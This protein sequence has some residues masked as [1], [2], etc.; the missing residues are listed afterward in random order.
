MTDVE[1]AEIRDFLRTEVPFNDL[2]TTAVDALPGKL[3]VQ[4]FRRASTILRAGVDNDSLFIVRSGAVELTDATGEFM[5]RVDVGRSFGSHSLLSGQP[6]G[7]T[8]T[9]LEDTLALVMP[10][11]VFH[12]LTAAHPAFAEFFDLQRASRMRG[13]VATLHMSAMGGA[14]LKTRVSSILSRPAVTAPPM[15][16][17]REAATIMTVSKVSS[18]L[19]VEDNDVVGIVTDRDLRSRALAIGMDPGHPVKSIMTK[20]PVTASAESLAFEVLMEMLAR[21]IH[22]LP[23]VRDGE[24]AGVITTTD[25]MRLEQANPVFLV[26]DI[27]KQKDVAGVAAVT[28]RLASVVETLVSQDASADDIGR[29]VT[30]VGDAVERRLI[31]LAEEKLG[32]PPVPFCWVS[33]GSRARQEQ[34]LAADQDN[35]MILSDDATAE[36]AAYFEALA[37]E[38]TSSLVECGYPLCPGD[39]MASNPRWRVTLSQWRREFSTWITEPVPDAILRASIFFDMRPIYGEVKLFRDLQRHV[40]SLTPES[41]LFLA[42]LAKRAGE[43]EPPIGFF[44]GF[45][46]QKAG[47]HKDTLDIKRGG[48]GSVVEMARVLALSIGSREVNTRA[49]ITAAVAA[50]AMS[51][52]RGEDLMD[53]LEFISYVRLRHQ[54]A[55]VRTGQEPNNFVSPSDLSTFERRNLREAFSIVRSAQTSLAQRYPSSYIS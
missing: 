42:H 43:N 11:P 10:G 15:A 30:A 34:A 23:V 44:R 12:E 19:I 22:H 54:A 45:V 24:P 14:I 39:I 1:L 3:K 51:A 47:D 20:N 27:V 28:Q 53:A 36:H 49:R 21:N 33:L 29:V 17:I 37:A 32:P 40:L 13:A 9:A 8:A 38:V 4:Y 16:T 25:L 52:E 18:L 55:K 5:D 41:R 35:A 48:I 7:Y 50:G 2:P 31:G 6:S 26:G 46:L